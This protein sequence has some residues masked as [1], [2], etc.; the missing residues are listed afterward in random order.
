M[1]GL[2]IVLAIVAWMLHSSI[3]TND[4]GHLLSDLLTIVSTVR[5]S[6]QEESAVIEFRAT[7]AMKKVEWNPRFTQ[8][9]SFG[10]WWK[11]T[12]TGKHANLVHPVADYL[13]CRNCKSYQLSFFFVCWCL[14]ITWFFQLQTWGPLGAS[15]GGQNTRL[16]GGW[17]SRAPRIHEKFGVCQS[18]SPPCRRS[19]HWKIVYPTWWYYGWSLW[20]IWKVKSSG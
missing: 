20:T 1:P 14:L 7:P 16:G 10:E 2:Q 9:L 5:K 8:M 12:H 4:C 18:C 19:D 3:V 11:Y 15:T 13:L 17:F 6:W